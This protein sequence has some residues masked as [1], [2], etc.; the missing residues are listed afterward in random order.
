MSDERS[1][2]EPSDQ[3][4]NLGTARGQDSLRAPEAALAASDRASTRVLRT[5]PPPSE[6]PGCRP[7]IETFQTLRRGKT[8]GGFSGLRKRARTPAAVGLAHVLN[9]QRVAASPR[10]HRILRRAVYGAV[11][12]VAMGCLGAIGYIALSDLIGDPTASSDCLGPSCASGCDWPD[13]A[14]NLCG[15]GELS[16][17][18]GGRAGPAMKAEKAK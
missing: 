5:E 4:P 15:A 11:G 6:Q 12:V 2:K 18:V 7:Q 8:D 17:G 1:R 13:G 9:T 16:D 3:G 10:D 14:R